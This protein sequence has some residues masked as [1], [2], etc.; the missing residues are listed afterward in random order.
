M[1]HIGLLL[2]QF[3][4]GLRSLICSTS[5]ISTMCKEVKVKLFVHQLRFCPQLVLCCSIQQRVLPP[6][7]SLGVLSPAK[8]VFLCLPEGKNS[9]R[10]DDLGFHRQCHV[11]APWRPSGTY[12]AERSFTP[13]CEGRHN[14]FTRTFQQV[15]N[16][17]CVE[18]RS[19]KRVRDRR[20]LGVP[21]ISTTC[22][23]STRHAW[24]CL[25]A[26]QSARPEQREKCWC[27]SMDA[28]MSIGYS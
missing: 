28:N 17:F 8:H 18:Q 4:T 27:Q 6:T 13:Q 20:R 24:R 22:F 10:T 5:D 21:S 15:A 26:D 7:Q 3:F 2:D 9:P 11:A 16:S 12:A 23:A 19:L 1:I 14:A 25:L